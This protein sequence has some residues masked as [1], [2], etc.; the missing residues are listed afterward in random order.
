MFKKTDRHLQSLK[1][2]FLLIH[3]KGTK[4]CKGK[5]LNYFF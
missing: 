4:D 1:I 2:F 5:T 3:F